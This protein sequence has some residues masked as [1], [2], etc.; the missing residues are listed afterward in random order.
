M[1]FTTPVLSRN[2]TD[3]D[4]RRSVLEGSFVQV[5][6]PSLTSVGSLRPDR[7][8]STRLPR[9]V[10]HGPSGGVPPVTE[11]TPYPPVLCLFGVQGFY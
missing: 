3:G 10:T 5:L 6:L 9:L 7:R 4:S 2:E 11:P 8:T 1:F